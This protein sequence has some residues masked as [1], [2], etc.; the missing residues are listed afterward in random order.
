MKR[1]LVLCAWLVVVGPASAAPPAVTWLFP[2]GAQRGTNVDVTAN[3]S[4]GRWPVQVHVEGQGVTAEAAKD[5][6]KLHIKVAADA[7]PGVAWIRLHDDEGASAARPF[8]IGTL[9][10]VVEKEPNDDFRKPQQ[11]PGNMVV[12]GRLGTRGDV[13]CFALALKKGQTLVAAL[14]ANE[15]FRS[16][17]D[18]VLQVVSAEGFVLDQNHDHANLDPRLVYLVP[19]D[20][21]YLVRVFAFASTPDTQIR[22][23]GGDDHIYRLTITTGGYVDHA[24]P[25]AI[26]RA[27]STLL[28]LHGWNLSAAARKLTVEAPDD[29]D[30][31]V[32]H[33]PELANATTV[34]VE[35]HSCVT[36]TAKPDAPQ[37]VT[38]PVTISSILTAT[39]DP[40]EVAGKKGQA[41]RLQVE[42]R[43]I[44]SYLDPVLRVL[45]KQG[46]VLQRVDDP[47]RNRDGARDPEL[48]FTPAEDG[49]YRVEVQDLHGRGG[50]G[51]FYRLRIAPPRPDFELTVAKDQVVLTPGKPLEI[52]V[53]VV[54]Q[55]GFA[56]EVELNAE[57]LPAGVTAVPVKGTGKQLTL[58]LTA[59]KEAVSGTFRISGC[60]GEEERLARAVRPGFAENTT[61]FWLTVPKAR[62]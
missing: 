22:F 10:E 33:H 53:T 21:I 39:S 27:G 45:D 52:A 40:Y 60:A 48:T 44:N 3:G 59:E 16:P 32:V 50:P 38:P 36:R 7:P 61:L 26:S 4:F 23:T 15:V 47:G 55:N 49:A 13:D 6:G 2:A 35:P 62:K 18:A 11:L 56:A 51:F 58:K 37:L 31:L 12:H 17:I 28:T 42:A 1:L 14:E 57:D 43:A 19:R 20:G 41:L 30:V 24:L 9:P 8:V 5:K 54:R 29:E 34:R 25:L 46:K